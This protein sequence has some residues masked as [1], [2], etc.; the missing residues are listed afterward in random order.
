MNGFSRN[1]SGKYKILLSTHTSNIMGLFFLKDIAAAW[2]V[3]LY[4][5]MVGNRSFDFPQPMMGWTNWQFA[6]LRDGILL[7]S[8][9][10]SKTRL[11]QNIYR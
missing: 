1:L 4:A 6:K 5:E 8:I 3:V 9:R 7:L 11:I 2:T 10:V